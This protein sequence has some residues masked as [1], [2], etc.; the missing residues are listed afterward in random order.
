MIPGSAFT[1]GRTVTSQ[2]SQR[3]GA[4]ETTLSN[5]YHSAMAYLFFLVWFFRMLNPGLSLPTSGPQC[6]TLTP[7]FTGLVYSGMPDASFVPGPGAPRFHA[8]DDTH[9]AFAKLLNNAG[10]IVAVKSNGNA[11]ETIIEFAG[12]PK[13]A[14]GCQLEVHFSAVSGIDAL[15]VS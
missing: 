4:I 2:H 12:L 1:V 8:L 7:S 6:S 14:W 9:K 13:D 5:S 15:R 3:D 11:V 10:A